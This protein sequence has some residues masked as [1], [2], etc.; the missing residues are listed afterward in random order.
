MA[1]YCLLVCNQYS[2]SINFISE[3]TTALRNLD[4]LTSHRVTAIIRT[5]TVNSFICSCFSNLQRWW[6]SE[7][8]ILEI[9]AALCRICV[10]QNPE[11]ELPFGFLTIS[12]S[13]FTSISLVWVHNCK[14][15]CAENFS[16]GKLW[17]EQFKKL[18]N[19]IQLIKPICWFLP[20][21]GHDLSL[22]SFF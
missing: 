15:E 7:A 10:F 16:F 17:L 3:T 22:A 18:L 4:K 12:Y 11:R 2:E 9:N 21:Q 8:N 14:F 19:L 1:W 6:M 5:S 13:V 20:A